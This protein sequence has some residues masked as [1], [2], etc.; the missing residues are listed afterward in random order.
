[1]LRKTIGAI[2]VVA[3]VL[4]TAVVTSH[5]ARLP[6]SNCSTSAVS[7]TWSDDRLY[8]ATIERKDCDDGETQFYSVRVDA[9]RPKE[10]GGG[11]FATYK[12]QDDEANP[13]G[14]PDVHWDNPRTLS[15]GMKT[16]TLR[17][18]IRQNVGDDLTVIQTYTA[19]APDRFPHF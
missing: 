15:I 1:M 11:W 5:V 18:S 9:D 12:V 16:Q 2:V 8:K 13:D 19:K 7:E 14:P 6:E 3:I 4:L 10:P 17:G